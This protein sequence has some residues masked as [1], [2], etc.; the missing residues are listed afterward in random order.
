MI[1][2]TTEFKLHLESNI[3]S[4][5]LKKIEKEYEKCSLSKRKIN[6]EFKKT[7]GKTVK[8][9][10]RETE[11]LRIKELKRDNPS[12]SIEDILEKVN[13][14]RAISSYYEYDRKHKENFSSIIP[15]HISFYNQRIVQGILFRLC[16]YTL[17]SKLKIDTISLT[18]KRYTF[19]VTKTAY[20]FN[21]FER[22]KEFIFDVFYD[23]L[24]NSFEAHFLFTKNDD[25][26][27][28]Y[29]PNTMSRY[30]ELIYNVDV[31][32]DEDCIN[33][34]SLLKNWD[35]LVKEIEYMQFAG[36]KFHIIKTN[37]NVNIEINGDSKF[38]NETSQNN[39]FINNSF[40]ND[41]ANFS[42]STYQTS[43]SLLLKFS[44]KILQLNNKEENDLSVNN[45]LYDF[46]L[47]NKEQLKIILAILLNPEFDFDIEAPLESF[48]ID[49]FVIE[50]INSLASHHSTSDFLQ[51]FYNEYRKLMEDETEHL[52][53]GLS[54]NDILLNSYNDY[55]TTI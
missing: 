36:F 52:I 50:K 51:Y 2:S 22:C 43:L 1:H 28:A 45:L 26:N 30:L 40:K 13:Y 6:E 39:D 23:K 21:L 48:H 25:S 24:N 19:D 10:F 16:V 12:F 11:Y 35:L 38:I 34:K 27:S 15:N 9:Y 14:D 37:E 55:I 20:Q 46:D 8:E 47:T 33:L 32:S 3:E 41:L 42:L 18:H 53:E 4:I 29:S 5:S 17:D 31:I 44:Q 54:D 7:T 49:E